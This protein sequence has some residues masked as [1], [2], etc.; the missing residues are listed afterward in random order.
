[1][2]NQRKILGLCLLTLI[3]TGAV[4]AS[5]A[6][7]TPTFTAEAYSATVLGENLGNAVFK[8]AGREV[9]CGSATTDG[10]LTGPS[11][12]L[13]LTPA[14]AACS[15]NLGTPR[16]ATIM[17]NGCQYVLHAT[18]KT[19]EKN[20]DADLDLNCPGSENLEIRVYAG[21]G[22][23]E[24]LCTYKIPPLG[25][26][27]SIAKIEITPEAKPWPDIDIVFKAPPTYPYTVVGSKL[28]C[29]S[30]GENGEF[31]ELFTFEYYVGGN[32]VG[33]SVTGE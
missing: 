31:P 24:V 4:A 18:K 12:T 9:K 2:A 15:V 19:G 11:S 28:L 23:T 30:S 17:A 33:G 32:Q 25:L 13:T 21:P 29:G 26:P 27:F 7:A 10:T 16:P 14:Y 3:A 6:Q 8:L 22:H 20:Y 1:M 5:A